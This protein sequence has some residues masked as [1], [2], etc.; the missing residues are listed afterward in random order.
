MTM[1]EGNEL[2]YHFPT[3]AQGVELIECQD[4]SYEKYTIEKAI[5]ESHVLD[6]HIPEDQHR[7]TSTRG[8][9]LK[10]DFNVTFADGSDLRGGDAVFLS[11]GAHGLFS[12]C[13]LAIN[14]RET[15]AICNY[16]YS[17]A[18]V[19]ALGIG[20][21]MQKGALEEMWG[22]KI[23]SNL[24]SSD[25]TKSEKQS[26]FFPAIA[27][28]SNSKNVSLYLRP[29]SDVLMSMSQMLPPG[30]RLRL[31]MQRSQPEFA[32]CYLPPPPPPTSQDDDEDYNEDPPP[33]PP[34]PPEPHFR[35]NFTCASLFVP[36][37]KYS[38]DITSRALSSI[39]S[40][41][42]LKYTRLASLVYGINPGSL[43]FRSYDVYS[44]SPLPKT[45]YAVLV[46][47]RSYFG[48]LSQLSCYFET[49]GVQRLRWMAGG[50]D[51]QAEEQTTQ[52]T[53]LPNGSL[54]PPKSNAIT[55]FV[56]LMRTLG[57]L[58]QP[59][60]S[61]PITYSDFLLGGFMFTLS[62]STCTSLSALSGSLDLELTFKEQTTEP[63]FL[64]IF[65]EDDAVL[66]FDGNRN[67][68]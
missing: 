21:E 67:V 49:A 59:K 35:I 42:L 14:G 24:T 31:C 34:P 33:P 48:S 50:R 57:L 60:Q 11:F 4:A 40:G 44:G 6:F 13:M 23:P 17:A 51:L 36:R 19:S 55:P 46:K 64:L 63:L 2:R 5:N 10:L 25:V 18:L 26:A 52:F 3:D 38:P 22:L 20:R 39:S 47:Q 27:T 15:P 58:T 45:I 30:M 65:S 12:H 54:F 53:Y 32:L 16:A 41:G 8:I 68:L 29:V 56:T 66:R 37:V 28:V 7:F 61:P 43:S 9:Y 62:L 1:A